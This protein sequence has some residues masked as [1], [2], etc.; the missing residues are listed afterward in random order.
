MQP[1]AFVCLLLK[2]LAWQKWGAQP[3]AG[4]IRLGGGGVEKGT[5]ARKEVGLR[6]ASW[7]GRCFFEMGG[8]GRGGG[9][10]L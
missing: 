10:G 3:R 2:Q 7:R 5:P 1:V 8:E 6:E 4:E 9:R